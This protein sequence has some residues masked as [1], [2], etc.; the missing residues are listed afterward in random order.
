M[1]EIKDYNELKN[2]GAEISLDDIVTFLHD[3][4]DRFRD[5]KPD[6]RKALD[7]ALSDAEGMGGF[8][9]IAREEKDIVGA[10]V[11][12]ETGMSGY[13]PENILV[14]VA[15]DASRRGKG[16][17]GKIVREALERAKGDVKLHVEHDNPAKRLYERLGFTSKYAEMRYSK[18]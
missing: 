5:S 14:Y 16:I 6:I 15:V 7:Y 9:L 10:L 12:N 1:I 3:H 13:I 4:L 17:G 8:I 18:R 2:E 11:M